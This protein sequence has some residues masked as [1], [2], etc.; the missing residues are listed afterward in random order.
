[1]LYGHVFRNAMLLD[2]RRLPGGLH[3]HLVHLRAADR[4][5]LLARRARACSASRRRSAR[6]PGDVRH[7]LHLH[8]ARPADA[9]R[10]RPRSTRWSIRA[11]T[12]RRDGDACTSSSPADAAARLAHLPRQPARLLVAVDLPGAVRASRLFAE[13]IANDRPLLVRYDGQLL[14]PGAARLSGDDVRR[15][16]LPTEADYR[17]P[18]VQRADRGEGLDGLAADPVQLRHDRHDLPGAG[19]V[20]ALARATGSA[21]TTRRATCWRG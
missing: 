17:D 3:R 12:S 20:A 18:D 21:P 16:F 14:F 5:H 8:A 2:R 15:R 7:A 6:L 4:D 11:S 13:F 10:R 19:A 1:M 9:D